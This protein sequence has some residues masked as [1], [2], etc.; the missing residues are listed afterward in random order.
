MP[1]VRPGSVSLLG[2]ALRADGQWERAVEHWAENEPRTPLGFALRAEAQ[3]HR[4][5]DVR[6]VVDV[7]Q[8]GFEW[9]DF[10][11]PMLYPLLSTSARRR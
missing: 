8:R 9:F 11:E 4:G 2:I 6:E 1:W 3:A 5:G 7:F 10:K